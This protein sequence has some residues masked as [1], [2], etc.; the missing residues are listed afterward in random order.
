MSSSL[1]RVAVLCVLVFCLL[2]PG[3]Q[4]ARSVGL[5]LITLRVA[6][7][8]FAPWLRQGKEPSFFFASQVETGK[9]T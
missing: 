2:L 7:L 6:L 8:F 3:Q 5:S 1:L 4:E 9:R